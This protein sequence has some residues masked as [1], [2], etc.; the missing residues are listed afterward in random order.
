MSGFEFYDGRKVRPLIQKIAKEKGKSYQEIKNIFIEQIEKPA[1]Q[2]FDKILFELANQP[3]EEFSNEKS[4]RAIDQLDRL[5]L[6]K[7]QDG[8]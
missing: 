8:S 3:Y 5:S 4:L 7:R 6:N 1:M 2:Q